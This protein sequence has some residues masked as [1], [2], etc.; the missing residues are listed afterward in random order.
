MSEGMRYVLTWVIFCVI[1]YV[2]NV[3]G[4]MGEFKKA[5]VKASLAFVP[6]LRE[7]EM[8][9]LVWN[10]KNIGLVWLGAFV[11]GLVLFLVGCIVPVQILGWIGFVLI[12]VAQVMQM[13]R[14]AKQSKSFGRAGGMT[15][16]LILV[17]PI[18]NVVIGRSLSEYKGIKA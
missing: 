2:L 18:A 3:I 1:W 10:K 8:Y 16:A 7:V 13:I 5:N 11:L 17:N 6:F 4:Y 14:A 12:V 15:A 9:K